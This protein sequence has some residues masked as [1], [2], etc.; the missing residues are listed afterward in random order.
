MDRR[1]F[2]TAGLTS[3]L[4]IPS[5][6]SSADSVMVDNFEVLKGIKSVGLHIDPLHEAFANHSLSAEELRSS[7]ELQLQGAGITIKEV[8]VEVP[9]LWI[10]FNFM[11]LENLDVLIYSVFI[12]VKEV[13]QSLRRTQTVI[14]GATTYKRDWVGI[15]TFQTLADFR[16]TIKN[17]LEV[18]LNDY[19]KANPKA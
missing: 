10:G 9:L 6:T 17:D 1:S 2:L 5:M 7:L 15:R 12:E 18:F 4:L 8:S 11:K 3:A 19:L 16:T 14:V 13:L